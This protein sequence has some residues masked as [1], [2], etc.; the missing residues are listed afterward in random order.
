LGWQKAHFW[1]GKRPSLL[2]L[3]LKVSGHYAAIMSIVVEYTELIFLATG[4]LESMDFVEAKFT[5][6]L[7]TR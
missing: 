1:V 4:V 5:D 2:E 3:S 7:R 6:V